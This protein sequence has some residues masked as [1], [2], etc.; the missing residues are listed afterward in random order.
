M[1]ENKR[2]AAYDDTM[3]DDETPIGK[4]NE[5]GLILGI[6]IPGSVLPPFVKVKFF[7]V[8][9]EPTR[10]PD[11]V[12]PPRYPDLPFRLLF[13]QRVFSYT[14]QSVNY[15]SGSVGVRENRAFACAAMK[16]NYFVISSM[17]IDAR[18]GLYKAMN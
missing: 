11:A 14:R 12:L 4:S 13:F 2:F 7:R 17:N 6:I 15:F 10:S 16:Y 18:A 1:F 9:Q 3:D 5:C 8:T